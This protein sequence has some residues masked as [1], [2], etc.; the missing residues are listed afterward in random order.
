MTNIADHQFTIT[1]VWFLAHITQIN[2]LS[3]QCE[4]PRHFSD[5]SCHEP[6]GNVGEFHI[7][8]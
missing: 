2:A 8:C 7:A 3:R 5:G 1:P 6:S 4:I